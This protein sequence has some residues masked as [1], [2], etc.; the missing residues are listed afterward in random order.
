[1]AVDDPSGK[2]GIFQ[3]I[4]INVPGGGI[5]DLTELARYKGNRINKARIID[6]FSVELL[7][8][9]YGAKKL[10]QKNWGQANKI[11]SSK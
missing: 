8:D 4:W 6:T 3:E 11:K 10:G 9:E 2:P 7:G 5:A 1:M